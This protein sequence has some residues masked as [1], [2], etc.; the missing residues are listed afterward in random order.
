MT[1]SAEVSELCA[2]THALRPL[3]QNQSRAGVRSVPVPELFKPRK[4]ACEIEEGL[5]LGAGS[6]LDGAN[7]PE[8]PLPSRK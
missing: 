5:L 1:M 7:F 3:S 6:W 2:G 4:R 8:T